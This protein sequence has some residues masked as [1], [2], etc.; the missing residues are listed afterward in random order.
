MTRGAP[1]RQAVL[2]RITQNPGIHKSALQ[3][4]LGLGWGTISYH[5]DVLRRQGHV[6]TMP[7]GRQLRVFPMAV[8]DEHMRWL[9]A[10]REEVP[11]GILSSLAEK[12]GA[13][14]E[15]ITADLGLSRRA[16]RRHLN[17]LAAQGLVN[18]SQGLA[19]DRF[20]IDEGQDLVR[21]LRERDP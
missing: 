15:E 1:T 7:Q 13:C 9:S 17:L 16:V 12:P 18:A 10:L 4:E 20:W 11:Q 3:R 2:D 5:L 19:R 21:N 14:I 8:P 6:K